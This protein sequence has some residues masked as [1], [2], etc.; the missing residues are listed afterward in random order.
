[1]PD[2]L[3]IDVARAIH[4]RVIDSKAQRDR[5]PLLGDAKTKTEVKY[6]VAIGLATER[7]KREN[8]PMAMIKEVAKKDCAEQ[9]GEMLAA[10]MGWKIATITLNA[11]H[12]EMNACQSINKHLATMPD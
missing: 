12:N 9:R 7:L 2:P 10:E 1:M 11:I 5:L 4:G 6:D 8:V 3:P